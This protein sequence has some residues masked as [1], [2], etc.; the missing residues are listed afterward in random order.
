MSE[1][2]KYLTLWSTEEQIILFGKP[3]IGAPALLI[4]RKPRAVLSLIR[5]L[6]QALEDEDEWAVEGSMEQ[7]S[8]EMR[9]R[10][11]EVQP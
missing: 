7:F 8:E 9:E 1:T 2:K 11:Y 3:E 5:A 4:P 6:T 10:D